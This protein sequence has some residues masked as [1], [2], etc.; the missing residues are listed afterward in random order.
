MEKIKEL[1]TSIKGEMM[2]F[3]DQLR[4]EGIEQGIERKEFTAVENMIR[5][6][7]NDDIICKVLEV[8]SDYVKKVRNR[9]SEN[10]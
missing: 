9:L 3:A 1:P 5:E 2:S 8:S 10:S 4:R 6:G 7:F